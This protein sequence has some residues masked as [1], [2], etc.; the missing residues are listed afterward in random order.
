M[1]APIILTSS[2]DQNFVA[3]IKKLNFI[4]YE[5]KSKEIFFI[6]KVLY[7]FHSVSSYSSL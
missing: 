6:V 2:Q 5:E 3:E 7:P 1:L 4:L